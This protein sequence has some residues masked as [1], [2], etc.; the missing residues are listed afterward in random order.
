MTLQMLVLVFTEMFVFIDVVR[1]CT[2]LEW[3]RILHSN[4]GLLTLKPK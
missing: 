3:G 2:V 4:I 1:V